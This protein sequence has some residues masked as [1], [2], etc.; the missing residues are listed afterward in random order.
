MATSGWCCSVWI[1]LFL[2]LVISVLLIVTKK[3]TD[4]DLEQKG[5]FF[6][7]LL[8]AC[9]CV[10]WAGKA[11]IVF[12]EL[13]VRVCVCVLLHSYSCKDKVVQER[14]VVRLWEVAR[15]DFLLPRN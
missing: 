3:H 13:L 15:C 14:G 11:G 5:C 10:S 6:V 12:L 9:L 1:Y 8:A 4:R 7:V 2:V